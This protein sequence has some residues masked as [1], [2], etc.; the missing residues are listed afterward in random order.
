MNNAFFE[1]A[2]EN[3]RDIDEHKHRDIDKH[4]EEKTIWFQNQ[5]IILQSFSK[6]NC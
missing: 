5:I 2:M 1:K 4:K 6:R 3:V